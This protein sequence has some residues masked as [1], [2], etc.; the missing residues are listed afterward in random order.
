[1]VPPNV[2]PAKPA[3]PSCADIGE[4]VD[5]DDDADVVVLRGERGA[6][7]SGR[8]VGECE[9]AVRSFW[10]D[11]EG[12]RRREEGIVGVLSVMASWCIVKNPGNKV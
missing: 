11:L 2:K 6:V 3:N 1:M 5:V 12:E 9:K 7:G 8:P 10:R 4:P